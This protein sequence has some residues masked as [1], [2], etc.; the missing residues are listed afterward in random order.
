MTTRI[1]PVRPPCPVGEV[2]PGGFRM[3]GACPVAVPSV[4]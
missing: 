4:T 2:E 1:D 3:P